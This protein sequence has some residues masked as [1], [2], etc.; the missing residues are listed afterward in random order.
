MIRYLLLLLC[1]T[2]HA[3]M[4]KPSD[5]PRTVTLH[6]Q[7]L[8]LLSTTNHGAGDFT[9]KTIPAE[10]LAAALPVGGTNYLAS[11]NPV[12]R[13]SAF[14][15]HS[16]GTNWLRFAEDEGNGRVWAGYSG[17]SLADFFIYASDI[18]F[19]GEHPDSA[20]DGP[21]GWNIKGSSLSFNA[22]TTNDPDHTF[23]TITRQLYPSTIVLDPG[24]IIYGDGSG[25]TNVPTA[26]RRYANLQFAGSAEFLN[27]DGITYQ[28]FT[29]LSAYTSSYTNGFGANVTTGLIQ[30]TSAAL[31]RL[32][33]T[34][35]LG[36]AT[37]TLVANYQAAAFISGVRSPLLTAGT[38]RGTNAPD[39]T[40]S[41]HALIFLH[42]T[43][44]VDLRILAKATAPDCYILN[45]S[46]TVSQP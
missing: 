12:V 39:C 8:V 18:W 35:T 42:P 2:A 4:I 31:Y 44:T 13:G 40:I 34:V 23:F 29:D 21:V 5:L 38:M 17:Y 30:P 9:S 22:G 3:Q 14:F 36:T 32:D 1:L 24:G 41:A 33:L 37:A 43:N 10:S 16:N 19:C 26:A 7:D 46:L 15:R 45:A 27:S 25:L 28:P 20:G 11:S 6:P